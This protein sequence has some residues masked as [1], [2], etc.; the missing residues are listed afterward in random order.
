MSF[1]HEPFFRSGQLD[2]GLGLHSAHWHRPWVILRFLV[3][4]GARDDHQ[5]LQGSAHFLEHL[6]GEN[7]PGIRLKQAEKFFKSLGRNADWG[8]IEYLGTWYGC[9]IPNELAAIKRT[10]KIFGEMLTN[11]LIESGIEKERKRIIREFSLDERLQHVQKIDQRRN[12]IL[13]KGHRMENYTCDV[14]GSVESV[15]KIP[16]EYLQ[17]LY[18]RFYT[19]ANIEVICVGGIAFQELETLLKDSPFAA[20]KSGERNKILQPIESWPILDPGK[21]IHTRLSEDEHV[22]AKGEF[23]D[24]TYSSKMVV[25]GRINRM[26]LKLFKNIFSELVFDELSDTKGWTYGFDLHIEP[27]QEFYT[28]ELT[29]RVETEAISHVD[30]AIDECIQNTITDQTHFEQAQESL[31]SELRLWDQSGEGMAN[32]AVHSLRRTHRIATPESDAAELLTVKF[33]D[34]AE[35]GQW[36]LPHRRSTLILEP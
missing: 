9:M 12:S 20:K 11:A 5:E 1:T 25:P 26:A 27:L 3:H 4:T 24:T 8:E 15:R 13:F 36:L 17:G 14:G 32:E 19:P 33:E 10:L 22:V 30:A 6:T 23:G 29:G 31:Y 28:L 7:I 2:N 34:M 21:D 16:K 18:D 35:I